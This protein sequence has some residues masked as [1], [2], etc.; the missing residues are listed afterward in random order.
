M[1]TTTVYLSPGMFGFARLASFSYFDHIENAIKRRFEAKGRACNVVVCD[2]HPTA[3]IRRRA[4]RLAKTVHESSGGGSD[5]IHVVG[6]STGGLDARLV[7]SPGV[8]LPGLQPN[9]LAWR[10]RLR[11]ITTI[12]TPH[13]G[14]PLAAFFATKSGQQVLYAVT[15]L[16][17][18]GLK[19]GAP[20]LAAASALAA[21][22]GRVSG[23]IELEI[24]ERTSESIIRVLDDASSRELRAFLRLVNEDQGS[25][26]QLTPEAM[27]LFQASV[28]DRPGLRYQCV[29][30]YAPRGGMRAL[31]AR[32]SSPW[33][34]V[35]AAVFTTLYNL[36]ARQ[37]SRYPCRSRDVA[38][39]RDTV[40]TLLGEVPPDTENDGVVPLYSQLWGDLVWIG[41][42]DHLDVVGHFPGKG[43]RNQPSEHV[44]WLRSGA[45]Y[46]ETRFDA[47]MDRIVGGMFLGEESAR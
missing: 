34:A 14:T 40:R 24:L 43:K 33:S 23:A 26:I 36:T 2:V 46:D 20:P 3:S 39:Q 25:V 41:R 16:T 4:V 22:F 17:V 6:H 38:G 31:L 10:S 29:A 5:L 1:A 45:G 44:D 8:H 12:N 21:A 11:S 27:D 13:Y 30:A 35:S 37:D 32:F 7:A 15:A 42:G 9:E 28:E 18:T 47:M 19:L